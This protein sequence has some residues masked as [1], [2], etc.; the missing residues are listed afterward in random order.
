MKTRTLEN[1]SELGKRNYRSLK[2]MC[3]KEAA[4][5]FAVRMLLEKR[6]KMF[7]EEFL[8]SINAAI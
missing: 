4:E 8:K 1:L 7:S 3:G 6:Y 5:K 2:A